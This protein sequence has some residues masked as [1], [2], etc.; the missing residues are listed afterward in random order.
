MAAGRPAV[1]AEFVL[2]A[3]DFCVGEIEKITGPSITAQVLFSD[4]ETDLGR[5]GVAFRYVIHSDD[6]TIHCGFLESP[7]YVVCK[8][9]DAALTRRI[10]ADQRDFIELVPNHLFS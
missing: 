8:C 6:K 2:K 3:D 4:L 5:I 9:G 7:A 1:D 10:I